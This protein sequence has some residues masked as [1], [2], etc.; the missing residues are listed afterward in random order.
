MD[1]KH[2]KM[3]ISNSES[4]LRFVISIDAFALPL[5]ASTLCALLL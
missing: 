4:S 5:P 2:F 1:G 3:R